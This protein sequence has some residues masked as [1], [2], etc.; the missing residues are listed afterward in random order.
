MDELADFE[1]IIS[2]L[3]SKQNIN[4]INISGVSDSLRAHLAFCVSEK[5]SAPVVMVAESDA[6][7]AEIAS[8]LKFFVG[9]DVL[10]FTSSD[11]L[12]YDVDV[13]SREVQKKRLEVL[14]ALCAGRGKITY[15]VTSYSAL[16]SPTLPYEKYK[17]NV[18]ELRPGD[19]I[20]TDELCER[21]S[22]LGYKR[23]DMVEGAGQFSLRG[24]IL[25][26]FPPRCEHPVRIE[27]FD[28]EVDSIRTFDK[29]SQR[30][31]AMIDSARITPAAELVLDKSEREALVRR[32]T[33]L[34]KDASENAAA[35]LRRD[36]ERLGQGI[37]FPSIEKYIPYIYKEIPTLMDYI[38]E[39]AVIFWCGPARISESAE[40]EE[41]RFAQDLT[42]LAE[43][44]IIPRADADYTVPLKKAVRRLTKQ[45][46]AGIS[47]IPGSSAEYR[48]K[49][50][51]SINSKSLAGFSG[52]IEL[53]IENLKY[54]K[55]AAYR[56]VLLGGSEAR[57]KSLVKQLGNEGISCGFSA[58]LAELPPGGAVTVCPGSISRGF[59]L[60]LIRAVVISDKEIFGGERKRKKRYGKISGER[61]D[62]FTDLNEGDYVVHRNYGIGRYAG[63]EQLAVEGVRKDYLKII[64][65]GGDC[66]YVPAD[67]TDMV[68]KHTA[69]D[70]AHVKINKLGGAD[71]ARTKQ[72]V[73][74][75]AADM[76]K[77]LIELYAQREKIPGIAFPPDDEWQSDFEARFPYEETEGQLRSIEE[78]KR[79]MQRPHPMDR[80]LC[81]DVGY[82]KTE[83][84]LRGAF[85][86][87]NGG[88]QVAY[89][90]PTTILANQH[91]N[92]FKQ[93]MKDYPINVAML[94]RFCTAAEEKRVVRGLS[95]GEVDVVIGTHKLLG[96]QIR[97]NK[98]GMLII[99]EEQRFG[100]AHKEKIKEMR[101]EVDVL[102]LSATPIPRTL[103]MSLTGIRDMSVI[104]E[105][106]AERFPVST[107]VMEYDED[108]VIEAINKE[109]GRGGQVYY[110]FNK[111]DGIFKTANRL[112]ERLPGARVAAAHGR[113]PES[114]LEQ[115]MTDVLNGDVDVLVCTTIIET[116]L[117]IPNVNTLIAENADRLGLAQLYQLR[118]RV[119]RSNRAA[120]AYLTYRKNKILTPE[121]EKRLLA[122]KEFTE[123]GSGFKIAMRD[124]EIRGA[125]NLI[126]ARQH[127]HM[128]AVGYEMYCRLLEEAKTE[129][130]GG[131]VKHK[132][133]TQID[134]PVTAY[135]SEDYISSHG[136]R[137][138]A[139]K[140]I[141][142][143]RTEAEMLDAYDE[144]EDRYGTVPPETN[145]L[146]RIS[147][148]KSIAEN[149]GVAEM[150]GTGE[151]VTIKFDPEDPPDMRP[152]IKLI[153][154]MPGKISLISPSNP[155]LI[156]KA[157]P[158]KTDI[159]ADEYLTELESIL[160]AMLS[161][162]H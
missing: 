48:P 119:G 29:D 21:L 33:R 51:F 87:V 15:L 31:V 34:K 161:D 32:L 62:N 123:F 97:F 70:G 42:D 41:L 156:I 64:Y 142:A 153:D 44:G 88:Y 52:K 118:G 50:V 131:E 112:A 144:I 115:I 147:L 72:K 143:I 68:Y 113:M 83:V 19:D 104:N 92:T 77:E 12:F 1:E 106:P 127:G 102:T 101:K 6:A 130:S 16:I 74:A 39:N 4:P 124:L 14:D 78:M 159:R 158:K 79:D 134:L 121:A 27:F 61:I 98:L 9:G 129:L 108:V 54:Y 91:Y 107:Y 38:S 126:G 132:T 2:A 59:E 117:D 58:G 146:M 76:A 80:L 122:I 95:T 66:L 150:I 13:R 135:I 56:I 141:A 90:V 162:E 3:K 105:P 47:A 155:R 26:F 109:L 136:Q 55:S 128:E 103:H 138:A 89:L 40:K 43:R 154:G 82:G 46:F 60:P 23:E 36:I 49:R 75:A 93:R 94:S 120:Y 157:S 37:A 24:G 110:L 25:D 160:K 63:I 20:G 35:V 30:T 22:A 28:T 10:R 69:R 65:K 116:G 18:I 5:L 96:K 148:I 7:A 17:N 145:N 100:V 111:V 149:L 53:L 67:Q 73:K 137:L 84:A 139:Y 86:A 99:D 85:K 11:L 152:V 57:A 133:D 81:G 71:W 125:G 151:R 114:E 140:R 45:K 8:D